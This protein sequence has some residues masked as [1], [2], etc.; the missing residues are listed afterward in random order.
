MAESSSFEQSNFVFDKPVDWTYDQCIALSVFKGFN[1]FNQP[2]VISCWKLTKEELE[3][4]NKTG[5]I[6]LYIYGE[7]MPPVSIEGFN[8]F[9]EN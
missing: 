5:R 6:W 7:G 3:E 2:V 1:G 8:P 4:V 9:R